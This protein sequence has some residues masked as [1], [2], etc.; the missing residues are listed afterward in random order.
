M[1][2]SN[3]I[4]VSSYQSGINIKAIAGDFVIVKATQ[5]VNY[6]NPY[7][8][9]QL[10]DTKA[11]GKLLGLYHFAN[12]GNWKAEADYFLR[13]VKPYMNNCVLVLDYEGGAVPIGRESWAKSFLD[14][15]YKQTGTKPMIYMGLADENAYN[16]AGYGV[17]NYALWV[18]Q[19]NS[20]NAVYGYSP[21]PLYGRLRNWKDLAMFQYTPNGYLP[22]Y[23]APLD[24][25][26]YY[27]KN[28]DWVKHTNNKTEENKE[29]AWS[30][31]VAPIDWGAILITKKSGLAIYSQPDND[32]RIGTKKL[33]YNTSWRVSKYKDGFVR[34]AKTTDKD[35]TVHEQWIDSTGGVLKGNPTDSPNYRHFTIFLAA[36]AKA[37]LHK[38]PA[39]E[40]YGKELP[41]G[42][43]F[44]AEFYDK[45]TGYFAVKDTKGKLVYVNGAKFLVLLGG[46]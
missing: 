17:T 46:N 25:D 42:T 44:K 10:N 39:G 26:V 24:L 30:V 12:A 45:K 29:M 15:V 34:V 41:A 31:K 7:M 1:A 14:Y 23:N 38:K 18:A 4:D 36:G 19:Y 8:Y 5:G 32:H 21:R 35:G 20:M 6:T 37:K 27:G 2:N 3:G 28:S 43:K 9:K 40:V 13:A 11:S 33:A 16:W 22:N